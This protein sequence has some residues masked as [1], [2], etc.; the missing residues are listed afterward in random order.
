MI[1]H[2]LNGKA[3]GRVCT[4]QAAQQVLAFGGHPFRYIKI[5]CCDAWEHLHPPK[6]ARP[7]KEGPGRPQPEMGWRAPRCQKLCAPGLSFLLA[8]WTWTIMAV[9]YWEEAHLLQGDYRIE[10]LV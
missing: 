10:A 9:R 8:A 4:D 3:L 5:S 1:E 7:I 2:A 6:P